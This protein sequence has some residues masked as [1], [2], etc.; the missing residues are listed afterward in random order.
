MEEYGIPSK[1]F[2]MVKAIY[3]LVWCKDRDE[4]ELLH[5]W[6]SLTRFTLVEIYP[7]S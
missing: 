5:V 2:T 7:D 4:A 6:I 1:L 3:E